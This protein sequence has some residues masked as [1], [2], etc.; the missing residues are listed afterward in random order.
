MPRVLNRGIYQLSLLLRVSIRFAL[1]PLQRPS[2]LTSSHYTVV[3]DKRC[4]AGDRD[5]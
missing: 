4:L 1:L 3:E 5:T 2:L